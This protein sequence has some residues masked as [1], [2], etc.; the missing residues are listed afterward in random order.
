MESP[1]IP[2][3]AIL[4]QKAIIKGA[5]QHLSSQKLDEFIKIL[6]WKIHYW[7]AKC[8]RLEMSGGCA[9]KTSYS[10]DR[11]RMSHSL[12]DPF[13]TKTFIYDVYS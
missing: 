12:S 10:G 1:K 2:C 3:P 11:C 6:Q 13:R 9:L 8:M 5:Y 4:R 7:A